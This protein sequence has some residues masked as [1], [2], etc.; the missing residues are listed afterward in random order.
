[1]ARSMT[2]TPNHR[3]RL[4]KNADPKEIGPWFTLKLRQFKKGLLDV[5]YLGESTK[6]SKFDGFNEQL[7]RKR[8]SL[9]TVVEFL[10]KAARWSFPQ[11]NAELREKFGF[12]FDGRIVTNNYPPLSVRCGI[13]FGVSMMRSQPGQC[14]NKDR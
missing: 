5:S 2:P 14:T 11:A 4:H 9:V 8:Q 13:L 7:V 12:S 6:L 10:P 1:M 3:T